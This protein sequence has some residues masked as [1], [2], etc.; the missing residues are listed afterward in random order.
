MVLFLINNNFVFE[1]L[2]CWI[3]IRRVIQNLINIFNSEYSEKI[4]QAESKED[5]DD[6]K[7]V[8][9]SNVTCN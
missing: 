7:I 8:I 5:V 3:F 9:N 6:S 4:I 2:L 1:T